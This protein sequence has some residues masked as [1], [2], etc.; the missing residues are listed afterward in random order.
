MSSPAGGLPPDGTSWISCR[1][2]FFLPVRILSRVFRGKFLAMLRNAFD[3]GRLS[4]YGRLSGLAD[5]RKFQRRLVASAEPTGLCTPS[6]RSVALRKCSKYLARY[7]HRVA[8]T[9]QRL[10]ALED[11]RVRF[12]WKDYAHGGREKTM[13]LDASEFLCRF[14]LHV[15]PSGFVWIPSLRFPVDRLRKRKGGRLPGRVKATRPPNARRPALCR[16]SCERCGAGLDHR[17]PL[18]AEKGR[19]LVVDT[20]CRPDWPRAWSS[21]GGIPCWILRREDPKSETQTACEHNHFSLWE[22]DSP[23]DSQDQAL[24]RLPR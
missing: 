4:F 11:G 22:A 3:Q 2:G 23:S 21:L 8:I 12:R 6:L 20:C 7:T 1:P 10:I 16:A 18:G 24:F 5:S 14:L 15:L 13:T 9:N 17:L 19:M